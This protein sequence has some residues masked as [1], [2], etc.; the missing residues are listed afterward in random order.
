MNNFMQPS[1]LVTFIFSLFVFGT[2]QA[3]VVIEPGDGEG[4]VITNIEDAPGFENPVCYSSETG[5]GADGGELGNCVTPP[6][7]PTGP[8]G[9]TGATGSTGADGAIGPTGATGTAGATGST[10]PMGPTGSTGVGGPTGPEGPPGPTGPTG[11]PGNLGLA[12]LSCPD[13]HYVNGFDAQG[14]LI[15]KPISLCGNSIIDD[16][17]GEIC[18]DGNTNDGDGCSATCMSNETCGNGIVDDAV[19]E[20]CDDANTSN[21]DEC[22]NACQLTLP[23]SCGAPEQLGPWDGHP[24]FTASVTDVEYAFDA[25][26]DDVLAAVPATQGNI[27]SGLSIPVTGA[28]VHNQSFPDDERFWVAD[29]NGAIRTFLYSAVSPVPQPGDAVSFTVTE[30]Q[31]FVGQPQINAVTNWSVDSSGNDVLVR[32][33]Q[34]VELTPATVNYSYEAYGKI[35]GDIVTCG[36]STTCWY[37]WHGGQISEVRIN[38]ALGVEAGSCIHVIAPVYYFQTDELFD[39]QNW[40]WLRSY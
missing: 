12:G 23:M 6:I 24:L 26:L 10:G 1:V 27:V 18:D 19:G 7:G 39:I 15:C 34:G 17:V 32:N 22:D 20:Q 29:G 21:L 33:G 35:L 16:I 4:V 5:E 25:G 3:D 40:D 8:T 14:G 36:P 2:L 28:I 9:P 30:V 38:D 31:N 37:F 11:A 13:R